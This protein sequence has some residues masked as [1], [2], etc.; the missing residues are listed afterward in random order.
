MSKWRVGEFEQLGTPQQLLMYAKNK[1]VDTAK[2]V[3]RSNI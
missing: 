3:L 2:P 1:N